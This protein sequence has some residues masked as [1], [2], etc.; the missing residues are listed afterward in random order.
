MTF[1]TTR[2]TGLGI[3]LLIL[4][5]IAMI[6]SYMI[7]Q[8]R[9]FDAEVAEELT[10][11][12]SATRLAELLQD[13]SF[14]FYLDIINVIPDRP[15]GRTEPHGLEESLRAVRETEHFLRQL[16]EHP[17]KSESM[18]EIYAGILA[19]RSLFLVY[20]IETK[21]DFPSASLRLLKSYTMDIQMRTHKRIQD[22]INHIHADI[23]SKQIKKDKNLKKIQQMSLI[24]LLFGLTSSLLVIWAMNRALNRP[25]EKLVQGTRKLAAGETGFRIETDSDA[26]PYDEIGQLAAA[27]NDMLSR[28]HTTSGELKETQIQLIQSAKLASVGELAAGV[29]H[30]LNQP[31]M[32]I[33]SMSQLMLRKIRK[34]GFPK[35][36]VEEYSAMIEKNSGKMI[37]IINHLRIF[38]RQSEPF[39]SAL[40]IRKV[41]EN[42]LL[43][44]S[45]QLR[46]RK[47]EVRKY[48]ADPLPPVLGDANQLEQVMLNLITNARDAIGEKGENGE[49][50]IEIRTGLS[51]DRHYVEILLKDSGKGITEE[52]RKH[53]FD[54]FFTTKEV[55]KGTGLGLSISYGIIENHKGSIEV[56]ESGPGGT[57]FRIRLVPYTEESAER[58]NP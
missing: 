34:G 49:K 41:I 2:N 17:G 24:F 42:S 1:R 47:I 22:L 18:K 40:H 51:E 50:Y 8:V 26:E 45:E 12:T 48:L 27:F 3:I 36:K 52:N 56:Y 15:P 23:Q 10:E 32:V 16:S 13:T 39:F 44:L 20:H 38:S 30:E 55:G 35:E 43:M 31:L 54:P 14:S 53:V 7:Q 28:L 19:L 6:P 29:A 4:F 9:C 33:R 11:L 21:S 46:L 58:Q 57:T 5:C 25:V 37:H